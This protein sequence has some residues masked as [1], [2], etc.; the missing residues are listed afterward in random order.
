MDPVGRLGTEQTSMQGTVSKPSV[1]PIAL[2]LRNFEHLRYTPEVG[3]TVFSSGP[4]S[5]GHTLEEVDS[6]LVNEKYNAIL[7]QEILPKIMRRN[8]GGIFVGI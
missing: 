3:F 8:K 1:S 4:T 2:L 5:H 7:S 6:A